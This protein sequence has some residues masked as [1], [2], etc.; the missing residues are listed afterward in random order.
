MSTPVTSADGPQPRR[1][2]LA[3]YVPFPGRTA[4][5][6]ARPRPGTATGGLAGHRPLVL[7]AGDGG[8]LL[9]DARKRGLA[10]GKKKTLDPWVLNSGDRLPY[11]AELASLRDAVVHRIEEELRLQEEAARLRDAQA[12]SDVTAG[13]IETRLLDERLRE[14]ERDIQA[15][16]RQLDLLALRS[17]RWLRFRDRLRERV[18]D[19]WLRARFPDPDERPAPRTPDPDGP[20]R[21]EGEPGRAEGEPGRAAGKAEGTD[22]G[23]DWQSVSTA[24]TDDTS[25]AALGE[26]YRAARR[27]TS[28]LGSGEGWEGLTT[29]PGLPRWLT[30]AL[31]L[32]IMAVEVPVYWVAYQPFH[33]VGSTSG[34]LM[35]GTLA[36]SSAVIMLILPH[37]AGHMLRW[38]SATGS[39]RGGWLPSLSLL[40]VWGGLTWLLGTLRARFVMQHDAPAPVAKDTAG[41]RGLGGSATGDT[42]TL[43]DRLHLTTQTVTWL[44]CA[45]LLLSGGVGFL[46]GL[47]REHPFLD[48]FRTALERRAELRQQREQNVADTE[49]ARAA[50]QTAGDR[51]EDRRQAANER[52]AAARQLYEAAAH[53]YLDGVMTASKDTAVSES[54]MRLSRN[55][56]LLPAPAHHR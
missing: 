46:L 23:D 5:Q 32:V 1:R 43:V 56:P 30:L 3:R 12:A 22:P 55:W 17:S 21:P 4:Q 24:G 26:A 53:D 9:A 54:A 37:L 50:Q 2:R 14:A 47:F 27:E 28:G 34:D 42:T 10:A 6:T 35:S 19:R 8:S 41:F 52:I 25:S 51:Q 29:R 45:L 39:P 49:R 15:A 20:G 11:F 38:R 40:G 36:V 33:G 44:F 7:D 16:L 31:L 48:A 13:E 18:E